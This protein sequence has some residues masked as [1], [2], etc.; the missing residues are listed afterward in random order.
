MYQDELMTVE[1]KIII[2]LYL[3]DSVFPLF[4]ILMDVNNNYA[5]CCISLVEV[6]GLH[7][8]PHL[9]FINNYEV[10]IIIPILETW[11]LNNDVLVDI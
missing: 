4:Y 2:C 6:S 1:F 10:G 11:K 7:L 8:L 5:I 3:F 9:L